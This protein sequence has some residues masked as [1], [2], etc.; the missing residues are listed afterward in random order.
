LEKGRSNQPGPLYYIAGGVRRSIAAREAGLKDIAARIVEPG[1]PDV[2]MRI[3]LDQLYSPKSMIIRNG[4]Y[5]RIEI[6][7]KAGAVLPLI[8]V[9]PLGIRGQSKAIPLAQVRLQ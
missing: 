3:D 7:M 6:A 5:L 2:F 9:Q 4:R 8:E 1:K